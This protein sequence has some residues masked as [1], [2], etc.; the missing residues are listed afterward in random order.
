MPPLAPA[1]AQEQSPTGR[2]GP[3]TTP[4]RRRLPALLAVLVTVTLAASAWHPKDFTTW[5]LETVW[6][7]VGLP[8]LIV[9]RKRFPLSSLLYCLLAA[10]GLILI[11]GG[12]Y[13]YAEVP[14]G[15]WIRNWF[16]L[17]R[18]PYD[19][20]GHLVQGFVPAILIRELLIRTSPLRGNRWLAP[21]TVCACLA[22]SA[23][24]EMLEWFSAVIGKDA[25]DAFLGTQG[26]IWDT[27]WDMFCCLIGATLALLLLSRLHDRFLSRLTPALTDLRS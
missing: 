23:V 7:I 19:R 4:G 3:E 16:D 6:V 1:P 21:L 12:H 20:L 13:T 14:A 24:F 8:L 17:S 9:L 10:H 26:D 2:P 18:N 5:V 11:T 25:A 27:Q 22:F 15:E